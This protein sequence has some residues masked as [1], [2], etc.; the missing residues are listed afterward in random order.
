MRYFYILLIFVV[1]LFAQI[2][3]FNQHSY[4]TLFPQQ[5]FLTDRLKPY[6][7]LLILHNSLINKP[8]SLALREI[9]RLGKLA[10]ANN[11]K[12]KFKGVPW[13]RALMMIQK[14]VADG[15]INASYKTERAKYALYPMK[16]GELDSTRRLNPGKTYYIYK[17]KNS[18]ISWDGKKFSNVDGFVAAKE[19]F[20]VVE[21]LKKH[22]NIKIITLAREELIIRKLIQGKIAAYATMVSQQENMEKIS[23]FKEMVSK[24]KIP[25]RNKDYFLIFSKKTYKDKKDTIEKMWDLLKE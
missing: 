23:G 3:D 9:K 14:G 20:A 7:E 10:N 1:S 13:K 11:I 25:I 5:K 19:N 15:L 22:D 16:N 24:E 6:S 2:K 8:N 21:D 12:V 18:T 17:N 4:K